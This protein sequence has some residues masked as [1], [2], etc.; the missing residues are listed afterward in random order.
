MTDWYS[1]RTVS[2]NYTK[3]TIFVPTTFNSTQLLETWLTSNFSSNAVTQN[4]FN[5]DVAEL[6]KLYPDITALGSPFGTGNE[7]FGLSSQ[8]KRASAM[9]GDILFQSLRRNQTQ[10]LSEHGVTVFAYMFTDPQ[11]SIQPV[12]GGE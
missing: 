1:L 9:Y 11:P 5:A 3:G 10:V 12:F 2:I 6:L 7:T 8:F 4:E